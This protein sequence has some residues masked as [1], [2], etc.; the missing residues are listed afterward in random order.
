MQFHERIN[1]TSRISPQEKGIRADCLL[2]VGSFLCVQKYGKGVV[3]FSKKK[4]EGVV[5]QIVEKGKKVV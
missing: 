5:R 4:E 2:T 1:S 3:R